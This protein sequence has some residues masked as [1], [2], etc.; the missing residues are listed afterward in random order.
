MNELNLV[1]MAR[2]LLSIHENI[3]AYVKNP[4]KTR[5]SDFE[6]ETFVQTWG[7]TSGGFGGFGGSA[8]TSQRTYVFVPMYDDGEKCLVFFGSRFAYKADCCDKF[9][10][11]LYK[12]QISG[13][14]GS[15][16]YIDGKGEL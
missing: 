12:R 16:K 5:V 4:T 10:E 2:E 6:L 8:M 13:V 14:A 1:T 11:D 3:S 15:G 7:N 9:K